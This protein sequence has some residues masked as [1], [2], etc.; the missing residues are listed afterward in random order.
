MVAEPLETP[1]MIPVVMPAVATAVLLLLHVPLPASL[2]V[3]VAPVQTVD[4][5][6]MPA[7]SGYTVIVVI[8][9]HPVPNVYVIT[10]VPTTLPV[11]TPVPELMEAIVAL[12]LLQLPPPV[13]SL[14]VV[15]VPRQIPN[16]PRIEVGSGFTVSTLVVR[17]P[18]DVSL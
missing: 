11:T 1:D 16:V 5:P 8:I 4:G 6:E 14:N 2:S 15:E 10:E 12:L 3:I 7:G 13:P 9:L 17:H 18:V